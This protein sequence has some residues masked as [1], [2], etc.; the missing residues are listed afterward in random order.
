MQVFIYIY[1]LQGGLTGHNLNSN[2]PVVRA[3][4]RV[5][6]NIE[7][8]DQKMTSMEGNGSC[9]HVSQYCSLFTEK[10]Y[11]VSTLNEVLDSKYPK[12]Q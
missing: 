2:T 10:I 4:I 11:T 9:L 1:T 6:G 8:D 3:G 12:E 7:N 5:I